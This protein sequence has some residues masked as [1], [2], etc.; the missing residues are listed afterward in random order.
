MLRIEFTDKE[1][2]ALQHERFH[3]PVPQVQRKMEALYLKSM[4]LS[5]KEISR[6]TQIC[7][8]TL[9]NY[10]A[11]YLTG[12]IAELKRLGYRGAINGLAPYQDTLEAEFKD[13]P[14]ATVKEARARIK[15]LTGVE[16]SMTR[17]RGYLYSLG[18]VRRKVAA[19]PAKA[20]L[21]A[22]EEFKKNNSNHALP[23]PKRENVPSFLWMPPTSSTRRSSVSSG[24]L[25]GS[26]S[27][28][29]RGGKG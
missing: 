5:H 9:R 27:N 25:R 29:R 19:V 12:G 26:S 2:A 15:E 22:Q 14:P 7:P 23:K 6:L 4:G 18:M 3:Y 10:F 20:N 8:N 1:I 21:A 17:V 28:H 24:A 13:H 11:E 16:R